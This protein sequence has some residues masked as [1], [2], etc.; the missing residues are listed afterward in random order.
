MDKNLQMED[1]RNFNLSAFS[2]KSSNIFYSLNN[3]LPDTVRENPVF[4]LLVAEGSENFVRYIEWLGISYEQNIVVLPSD[5]NY[6]YDSDEMKSIKT[7]ISLKELN[8]IKEVKNFLRTVI[9]NLPYKSNFLGCFI[10]NNRINAYS[11]KSHSSF[12]QRNKSAKAVEN[13]IVSD[14]PFINM[15]YSLLDS[16]TYKS[17]TS[18]SVSLLLEEFGF[19]VLDMTELNGLTYFH[20]QKEREISE[21]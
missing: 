9:R 3:P 19:K 10:D 21:N 17:L 7:V 20:A 1:E 4:E 18:T 8:K 11:L 13:D 6:F 12:Y 16:R 5:R 2:N 14:M 15:L